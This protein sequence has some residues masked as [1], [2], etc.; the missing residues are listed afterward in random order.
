ARVLVGGLLRACGALGGFLP[1]ISD[2]LPHD[3]FPLW[4]ALRS[5]ASPPGAWRANSPN[6]PSSQVHR[7]ALG[8]QRILR[9][10]RRVPELQSSCPQR[11]AWARRKCAF[12]HLTRLSFVPAKSLT[13]PGLRGVET[14][15]PAA[16]S[17]LPGQRA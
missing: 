6:A 8:S 4:S 16:R 17:I 10:K 11:Y 2:L 3:A 13:T 9:A 12:A 1:A 15:S 5:R 14:E 7:R